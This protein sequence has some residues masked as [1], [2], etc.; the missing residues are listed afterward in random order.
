MPSKASPKTT[1]AKAAAKPASNA[2]VRKMPARKGMLKE[3]KAPPAPK[4]KTTV[5]VDELE[6]AVTEVQDFISEHEFASATVTRQQSIDF[7]KDIAQYCTERANEIQE[8]L[9]NEP[10]EESEDGGEPD[11]DD[12]DLD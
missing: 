12:L 5:K 3:V 8:E 2:P 11:T 6:A 1:K 9:D 10:D 4:S 7:H